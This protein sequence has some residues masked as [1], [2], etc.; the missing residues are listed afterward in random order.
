[1]MADRFGV[2]GHLSHEPKG[3]GEIWKFKVT[4]Q[5]SIVQGPLRKVG[6][7]RFEIAGGERIH[8]VLMS[9]FKRGLSV[10]MILTNSL[11]ESPIIF[12]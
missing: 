8:R 11:E 10:G 9:N 5:F 1:M 2:K 7:G 12:P 6:Q 4:S 3:C